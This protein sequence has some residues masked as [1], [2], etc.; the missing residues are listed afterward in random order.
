MKAD[1]TRELP[2]SVTPLTKLEIKRAIID[3]TF[4]KASK[5][6]G[7]VQPREPADKPLEKANVMEGLVTPNMA[8]KAGN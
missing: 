5:A 7:A 3:E 6:S 2:T 1:V 4:T 8:A